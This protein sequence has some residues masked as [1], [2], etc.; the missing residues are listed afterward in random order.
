MKVNESL[1]RAM[2]RAKEMIKCETCANLVSIT[3][4]IVE[5]TRYNCYPTNTT[6]HK[7]FT[8]WTAKR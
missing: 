1:I 7:A 2:E 4:N 5:C 6:E 3:G 8:G